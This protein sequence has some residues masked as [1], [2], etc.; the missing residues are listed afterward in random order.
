MKF[1]IALTVA[2]SQLADKVRTD[3]RGVTAIEYALIAFLIAVAIIGAVTLV[4]TQLTTT[5]TNISTSL[6]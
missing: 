4:G 2:L 6:G 3:E 5:F 1:T